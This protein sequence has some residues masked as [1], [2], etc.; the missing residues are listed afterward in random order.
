MHEAHPAGRP[1]RRRLAILA[2]ALSVVAAVLGVLFVVVPAGAHTSDVRLLQRDLNGIAYDAGPV[3]G[4]YGSRTIAAVRSFQQDNRLAV[5]GD[6]GPATTGALLEKVRAVQRVAGT[7]ADGDYGAATSAAVRGWQAAHGL[8]ADGVAGP[9]T[10]A[11]M[12]IP[13]VLGG[14]APGGGVEG[15]V[16]AALSQTG[17]GLTY[18]WAAGGK[19][20]P[21]YGVCCS[22]AGYDDRG[23]YGYDCSGLME[24]AFWQGARR[25]VG[26]WTGEQYNA[27]RR[28][29]RSQLIRGDMIFWGSGSSTTHV[30]LYLGNGQMVEA[31][32]PRTSTSVHVTAVRYSSTI[33]PYVVRVFG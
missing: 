13:R 28:V 18:S 12:G 20:G 9:R 19:N 1:R 21:S 29:P 33:K 3:D 6:A 2:S 14:P 4:S 23:R 26:G 11:A 8:G 22:P 27:G 15:V 32:S 7:S 16:A 24:Y 17:K 31:S 5:D 25:S 10:M 30:A